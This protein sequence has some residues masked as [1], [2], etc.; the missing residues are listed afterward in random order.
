M[1]CYKSRIIAGIYAM[2]CSAGAGTAQVTNNNIQNGSRLMQDAAYTESSTDHATVEWDC[3]N[4]SLKAL[5]NKCLI[6]HND[7]WFT[8]RVNQSGK[9][10]LNIA[11]LACRDAR[12][13]QAIILQGN[14]CTTEQYQVLKCIPKIE[15]DDVFI[16]IDLLLAGNDY[17][18]NIDGFLGDFCKFE[19]QFSSNPKGFLYTSESLDTLSLKADVTGKV[20]DLHWTASESLLQTLERFEVFRKR[21]GEAALPVAVF[22]PVLNTAGKYITNYSAT[23]VLS[24]AGIYTYEVI[25]VYKDSQLKEVLDRELITFRPLASLDP[26]LHVSLDYKTGT[27]VQLMLI[28]EMRDVV[29]KQNTFVF[30]AR[31]DQQQK[32]YIGDYLDKGINHFL[33][34]STNL[35]TFEKRVYKFTATNK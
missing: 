11:S 3:V 20:V 16:E 2:L 10:Y 17:F 4:K 24:E 29:L 13:I 34:V 27:K 22:A 28:D 6:Y 30:N 35:K 5:T 8:F 15:G 18:V 26:Y 14:P 12:G 33:V 9:Y 25:A 32:I 7:Q 1:R 21:K 23:D 19:I 31:H